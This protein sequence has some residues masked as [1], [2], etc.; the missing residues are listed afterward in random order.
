MTIVLQVITIAGMLALTY[1]V[2]TAFG[3]P[4]THLLFTK[5]EKVEW[6]ELINKNAGSWFTSTNIVGTLTSLATVYVFFIGSSKLFGAWI[7]LCSLTIWIGAYITNFFTKRICAD[8][9]VAA[10]L[11]SPDQTGGIIACLFWRP[12]DKSAQRTSLIIKWISL[13]NIASIIWLDFALFAD[14]SSQ[15]IGQSSMVVKV[16]LLSGTCL[17]VVFFT[18]HYGLRGFV[19]ADFFQAPLVFIG[20]LIVLGGVIF[21]A[22]SI[23]SFKLLIIDLPTPI[24]SLK[25]CALFAVQVIS[26]NLLLVLV[27]E[28]HWLRVWIF[29]AKETRLQASSTFATGILWGLLAL[30]GLFA[31]PLSGKKIGEAAIIS[32]LQ[33]MS[34]TSTI[35]IVAFWV[36]GIAA[37]FSSADSQIYSFLLVK[38]FQLSTGKLQEVLMSGIKPVRL[39][40][41]TTIIFVCIYVFVRSFN[42]PFEKMIFVVLPVCLN[43]FP[44]F[45]LAV[46]GEK[47]Q[48]HFI[49]A[50]LALYIGCSILGFLQPSN[51]FFWTLLAPF[52]P[53]LVSAYILSKYFLMPRRSRCRQTR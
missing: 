43:V 22:F 8:H 27:T 6:D 25:D 1:F 29:R 41:L 48:P 23:G 7:F 14:I 44:A 4:K 36:G 33:Q 42:V 39:S 37:L 10:R 24:L 16:A 12:D 47:Q 35:F 21:L 46:L 50:S 34:A 20:S 28:P 32:L 2:F 49:L 26:L 13:L 51:E 9:Y 45:V 11:H 38:E 17:A 52:C 18:L 19:F 53:V 30:I 40:V 5:E 3:K 15:L 31:F